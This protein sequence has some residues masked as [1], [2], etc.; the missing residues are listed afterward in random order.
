MSG[1]IQ[2]LSA[3]EQ[4]RLGLSVAAEYLPKAS[5][6]D[7]QRVLLDLTGYPCFWLDSS[8]SPEANLRAQLARV[9]AELKAGRSF[10]ELRKAFDEDL[11]ATRGGRLGEL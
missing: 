9:A 7:L 4:F 10:K 11:R 8:M 6:G 5:R 2:E 3:A 1:R